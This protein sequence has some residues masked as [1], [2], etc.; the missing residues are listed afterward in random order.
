MEREADVQLIHRILSGDDEAFN[1]LVQKYEKSIHTLVWQQIDDFH[2]AEE[3]TQDIFL[4]A[5][6]K[7]S[8][9]KD[10]NQFA[11]WL[12]AV[13]NRFCIDWIRKQ[14]PTMQS[15]ED[16]PMRAIDNLT[17]ERYVSEQCESEAIERRYEIVE[18]ILKKLPERERT[19]MVLHYLSEMTAKEISK[20]LGVSVNTI[21]SR[22]P[23]GA[24]AFT[25][26]SGTLDS[27]ISWQRTD[28]GLGGL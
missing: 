4:Q 20:S 1:R 13:A 27:G 5:Y 23:S 10:P 11:G 17:Y 12:Y 21:R 14:K 28:N 19:V 3:I 26:R 18:D 22:L 24:K 8:T 16:T 25:S 7:L 15:L 2:Y 6:K 9:L